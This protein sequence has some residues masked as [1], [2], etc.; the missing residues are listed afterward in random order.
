MTGST[1]PSDST[2]SPW[3]LAKRCDRMNPSVIREILKLTELPGVRSLAGG[4][5][6]ADTFPVDAMREGQLS[7][8]YIQ[9]SLDAGIPCVGGLT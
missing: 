1:T 5:P 2:N 3:K 4:L 8:G 7:S 6:S 9:P